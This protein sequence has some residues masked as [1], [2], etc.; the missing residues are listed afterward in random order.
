VSG[1]IVTI[2]GYDEGDDVRENSVVNKM[3][4][5]GLI[6]EESWKRVKVAGKPKTFTTEECKS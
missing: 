6:R 3:Q 5:Q 1:S 4:A 2:S